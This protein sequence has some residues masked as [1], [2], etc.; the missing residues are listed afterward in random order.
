MYRHKCVRMCMYVYVHMCMYMYVRTYVYLCHTSACEHASVL[1]CND[2]YQTEH[3]FHGSTWNKRLHEQYTSLSP[4]SLTFMEVSLSDGECNYCVCLRSVLVHVLSVHWAYDGSRT[5]FPL[6]PGWL[7]MLTQTLGLNGAVCDESSEHCLPCPL[8]S[9]RS[10]SLGKL[11]SVLPHAPISILHG[12]NSSVLVTPDTDAL[13]L[14]KAPIGR[15]PFRPIFT[16]WCQ[17]M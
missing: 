14:Y 8:L 9:F 10:R 4:S 6:A 13:I 2:I 3:G 12:A 7:R 16:A 11:A 15:L 5:G 17:H 1:D